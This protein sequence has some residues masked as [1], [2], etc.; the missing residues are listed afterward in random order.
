VVNEKNAV[1]KCLQIIP[2]PPLYRGRFDSPKGPAPVVSE[3]DRGLFPAEF[4]VKYDA[5]KAKL[6]KHSGSTAKMVN[7]LVPG[8]YKGASSASTPSDASKLQTF[9]SQ[10]AKDE[11]Q[12]DKEFQQLKVEARNM[13]II[14]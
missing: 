9:Y 6:D 10:H 11:V 5:Y 12:M 13:G 1:L 3:K 7:K 4:Q 8:G 2:G 14:S